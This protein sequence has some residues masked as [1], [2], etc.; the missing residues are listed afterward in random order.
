MKHAEYKTLSTE[1]QDMLKEIT[2][3]E[4]EYVHYFRGMLGWDELIARDLVN[5]WKDDMGKEFVEAG[6]QQ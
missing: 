2:S 1:A 4:G 6:P 5:V 3:T